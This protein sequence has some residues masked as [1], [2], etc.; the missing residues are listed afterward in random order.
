MHVPKPTIASQNFIEK[1]SEL[2]ETMIRNYLNCLY[3]WELT[4]S[5]NRW[6]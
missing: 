1:P 2:Y 6:R 5:W 4:P 3:V